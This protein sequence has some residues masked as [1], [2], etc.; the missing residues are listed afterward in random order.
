MSPVSTSRSGDYTAVFVK[1]VLKKSFARSVLHPVIDR[2]PSSAGLP[3]P[4]HS[5]P[6]NRDLQS[7][8][9]VTEKAGSG[10]TKF[11]SDMQQDRAGPDFDLHK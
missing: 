7:L 1:R 3:L 10:G 4:F 8:A 9:I 2:Y 6:G 11:L 5:D